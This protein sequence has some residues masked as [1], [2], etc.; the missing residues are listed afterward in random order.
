ML[1][2]SFF[3]KIMLH[4]FE[5]VFWKENDLDPLTN[6]WCE[7]F[8]FPILNHKLL[9][10]I[11]LVEIAIVQVLSSDKN[12][13]TFNIVSFMKNKLRNSVS[14]HL[15]LCTRFFNQHLFTFQSFL[16]IGPLPSRM[17][18]SIIAQMCS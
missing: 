18:K 11:K 5:V 6:L 16:M 4:D 10:Y 12:N 8:S 14:T 13:Q 1:Q 15:D 9:E 17:A 3:K 2:S 7:V